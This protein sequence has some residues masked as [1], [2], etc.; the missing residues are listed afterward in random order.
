MGVAL[1]G[2][3][4]ELDEDLWERSEVVGADALQEFILRTFDIEL[5]DGCVIEPE[6]V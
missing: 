5:Q 4:M 6:I 2:M 1:D 3:V